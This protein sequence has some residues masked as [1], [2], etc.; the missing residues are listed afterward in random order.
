[1]LFQN[2]GAYL[3]SY[4]LFYDDA[5]VGRFSNGIMFH[6]WTVKYKALEVNPIKSHFINQYDGEQ[7]GCVCVCESER[8]WVWEN[9]GSYSRILW[10]EAAAQQG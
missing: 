8:V 5:H 7:L 10:L 9:V 1:M 3:T 4:P 6:C 2:T